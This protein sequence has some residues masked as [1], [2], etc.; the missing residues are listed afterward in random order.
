MSNSKRSEIMIK[1]RQLLQQ[2][3][4]SD[5]FRRLDP[6]DYNVNWMMTRIE[7]IYV[8]GGVL[9]DLGGGRSVVNLVLVDLGME[10]FCVDLMDQYFSPSSQNYWK[11]ESFDFHLEKGVHYINVDM[12][13]YQFQEFSPNSVDVV[14]SHHAFEHLHHSPKTLLEHVKKVL[15]EGGV[16]FLEVPNAINLLKRFKVLFGKSNHGLYEHYF[17]SEKFCGHVREYCVADLRYL[18]NRDYFKNCTIWGRNYYGSMYPIFHYG[19][20]AKTIDHLLRLRPGLCS[21]LHLKAVK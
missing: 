12:L 3:Y 4:K 7:N 6:V 13:E 5:R 2:Y 11:K 10:V 15:K 18:A 9:I 8:E 1:A 19:I 21:T 14:C 17:N 16:F 20:L